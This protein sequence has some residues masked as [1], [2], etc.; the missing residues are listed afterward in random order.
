MILSRHADE[1]ITITVPPSTEEQRIHVV[2]VATMSFKAKIGIDAAPD[3]TVHRDEVQERIERER[4][5][6]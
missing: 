3:V 4:S 5:E 1:G 6:A 2:V